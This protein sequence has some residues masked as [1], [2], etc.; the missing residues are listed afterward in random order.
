MGDSG[1][2]DM[3]NQ[4]SAETTRAVARA[5]RDLSRAQHRP[6]AVVLHGGEP[7][8]LGPMKLRYLISILRGVLPEESAISLQTNGILINN[9]ILDLC[10]DTRVTISVSLDGPQHIHDQFR[11][12]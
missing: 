8:L 1:W 3:P 7:L 2:A 4:I 12:G 11:I 6:F 5:L 10:S 9:E